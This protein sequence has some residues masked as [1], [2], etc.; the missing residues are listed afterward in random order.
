VRT[1]TPAQEAP[2]PNDVPSPG[3]DA[4]KPATPE[5]SKAKAVPN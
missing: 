2:K 5:G 1:E 3:A 4:P